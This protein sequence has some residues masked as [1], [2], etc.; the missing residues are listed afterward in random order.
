MTLC[1]K[2]SLNSSAIENVVVN[3]H[4]RAP[5]VISLTAEGIALVF[6]VKSCDVETH[7]F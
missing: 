1:E 5:Q 4:V 7:G 6:T 3:G 2:I